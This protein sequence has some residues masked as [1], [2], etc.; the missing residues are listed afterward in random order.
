MKT[1]VIPEEELQRLERRFGPDVRRMGPW[2]SDGV[3]G[4]ASI[5]LGA[6]ESAAQ[7]VGRPGLPEAVSQ[8]KEARE[9]V[10]AFVDL[11][12]TFGPD[13]VVRIKAAYSAT[14][15]A[16]PFGRPPGSCNK[17]AMA[18]VSGAASAA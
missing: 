12:E 1:I 15:S 14:A 16:P 6:V 2:N 17:M 10:A 9:P 5:S 4:Y 13:L 3:F 11:V 7:A 8:L 18:R